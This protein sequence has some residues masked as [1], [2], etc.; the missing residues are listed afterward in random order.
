MGARRPGRGKSRN[1]GR[2]CSKDQLRRCRWRPTPKEVQLVSPRFEGF[3]FVKSS[4]FSQ[5]WDDLLTKTNWFCVK[6]SGVPIE[7]CPR[8]KVEGCENIPLLV[9]VS[10]LYTSPFITFAVECKKLIIFRLSRIQP[11][12]WHWAKN[13][14][15]SELPIQALL[16][17][18]N[19]DVLKANRANGQNTTLLKFSGRMGCKAGWPF[20]Q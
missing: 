20:D 11:G 7:E 13:M 18:V 6:I 3:C 10:I 2:R 15:N 17:Q 9:Q 5:N 1:S 16:S 12:K 19:E 4:S 14:L 8:S